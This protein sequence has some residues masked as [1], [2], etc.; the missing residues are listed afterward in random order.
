LIKKFDHW[1]KSYNKPLENMIRES[2][3][4]QE[5]VVWLIIDNVFC[6]ITSMKEDLEVKK[7]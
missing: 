5:Y 2:V 1:I 3:L 7:R 4:T 6:K